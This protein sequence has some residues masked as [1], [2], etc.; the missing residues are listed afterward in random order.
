LVFDLPDAAFHV[1]C[2]SPVAGQYSPAI[3]IRG[4]LDYTLDLPEFEH[5]MVIRIR[6]P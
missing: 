1:S 5:D 6:K 2:F 3:E 4:K